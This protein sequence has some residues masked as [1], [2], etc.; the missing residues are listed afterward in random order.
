M[1]RLSINISTDNSF[2]ISLSGQQWFRSG[3][4]AVRNKGRWLCPDNGSLILMENYTSS[5]VDILGTYR[6]MYFEYQG[7]PDSLFRFTTFVRVYDNTGAVIFGHRFDS[8]AEETA[9]DS[10]DDV[11]SSFPS[12][13]LEDNP[14]QRGYLAFKRD[15]KSITLFNCFL[16]PEI[17]KMLHEAI[18]HNVHH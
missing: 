8:G 16:K 5:G 9:T 12:I 4:I 10:A 15:S 6:D 14:I 2:T 18:T 11:I 7:K 3:P 17:F 1:S 13:L